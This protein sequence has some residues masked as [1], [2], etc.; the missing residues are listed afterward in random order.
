MARFRR[1][2]PPPPPC[3]PLPALPALPL[4][5][6]RRSISPIWT[7]RASADSIICR[8]CFSDGISICIPLTVANS[9]APPGTLETLRCSARSCVATKKWL[10]LS[11]SETC[12]RRH[13]EDGEGPSSWPQWWMARCL[14]ARAASVSPSFFSSF[15]QHRVVKTRHFSPRNWGTRSCTSPRLSS[16]RALTKLPST[17]TLKGTLNPW[18]IL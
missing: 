12:W 6:I 11:P 7:C 15:T 16:S 1:N 9:T 10:A 5:I 2:S 3:P 14:V 4:S 8:F 17:R 13:S 18:L